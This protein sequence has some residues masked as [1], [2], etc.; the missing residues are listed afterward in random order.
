MSQSRIILNNN[1]LE[2]VY[3]ISKKVSCDGAK[4]DTHSS[5]GHPLVYLDMGKNDSVTCPYC[6]RFFTVQKKSAPII[7]IKHQLSKSE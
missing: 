5:A 3:S 1:P 4:S 6:S 7:S 2:T